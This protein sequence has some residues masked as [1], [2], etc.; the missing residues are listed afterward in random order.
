[1]HINRS[2]A[3]YL[4]NFEI[5]QD[6]INLGHIENLGI[7]NFEDDFNLFDFFFLEHLFDFIDFDEGAF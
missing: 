2:Q 3:I 1:M 5:F 6:L 7:L 4:R